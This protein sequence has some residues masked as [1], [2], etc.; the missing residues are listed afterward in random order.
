MLLASKESGRSVY[1]FMVLVINEL[2]CF[3]PTKMFLI[4]LHQTVFYFQKYLVLLASLSFPH[5]FL[6]VLNPVRAKDKVGTN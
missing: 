5:Q 6:F 1:S 4:P 2:N 3:C